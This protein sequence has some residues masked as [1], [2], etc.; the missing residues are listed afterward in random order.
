MYAK[1][2][3]KAQ[4][5]G[6]ERE[7]QITGNAP[8]KGLID[9]LETKTEIKTCD[10]KVPA[11]DSPNR[12]GR[13][14]LDR[15]QHE[16]LLEIDGFYVFSVWQGNKEIV[17]QRISARYLDTQK[18]VSARLKASKSGQATFTWS[19]VIRTVNNGN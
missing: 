8:S 7:T 2:S 16:K 1:R 13:F 6:A 3:S 15:T 12:S 19:T 14:V 11:F 9:V 10:S 5:Q 17:R 18:D 4:I